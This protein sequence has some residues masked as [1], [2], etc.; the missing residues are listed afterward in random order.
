[1]PLERTR[2]ARH[3]LMRCRSL[4]G[5]IVFAKGWCAAQYLPAQLTQNNNKKASGF[6]SDPNDQQRNTPCF[7]RRRAADMRKIYPGDPDSSD[8]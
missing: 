5:A 4:N 7:P 6:I 8:V 2:P 3:Y 1:M